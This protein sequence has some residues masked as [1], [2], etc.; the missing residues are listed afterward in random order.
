MADRQVGRGAQRSWLLAVLTVS[1]VYLGWHLDRGWYPHDEGLLGQTAERVLNGE[2]PHRDFDEPYTGLL[3]YAHALAFRVGGIQL[4]VLRIPL[5][6][7]CLLGLAAFFRIVIRIAKP[8]TAASLTLV[9]LVWSV[10]NYPA[11]VP[12]WYNLFLALGGTLA[13]L[14]GIE[15]SKA[16]WLMLAGLAGGL[17][18]LVKLSG[19]F[20]VAGG[21]L[22]LLYLSQEEAGTDAGRS[23]GGMRIIITLALGAFMLALWLAV[24]PYYLPRVILH[25]VIPGATLALGLAIREWATGPGAH[26]WGAL[27]RTTGAFLGGF[28][29]P[30]FV[31]LGWFASQH[32]LGALLRDVFLTSFR[33]VGFATMFPPAPFWLL[34]AVPLVTL[35]RPR[36]ESTGRRWTIPG[37]ASAVILAGLLL[38]ASRT[39]FFYRLVW[40]SVRSAIPLL[41]IVTGGILSWP[42]LSRTWSLPAKRRFALLAMICVMASLVQFPFSAPIYFL[43]VAPLA[44]LAVTALVEAIG[45]T[46]RPLKL[47]A[48]SF[49]AF[50]AILLMNPVAGWNLGFRYYHG[51]P[52]VKLHLPRA[53]IRVSPGD[54]QL[55]QRVVSELREAAGPGAIWA[56]PDAPELYFLG[57]FRNPTRVLFDFLGSPEV[58]D[59]LLWLLESR[60]VKAIAIN[61]GPSFSPPLPASLVQSLRARYPDGEM[62]GRFEVRRR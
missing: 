59:S 43:Y 29:A 5:L 35:L 2:M 39:T 9:A 14:R 41:G 26:Q 13:L 51:S 62:F 3:T 37:W 33:R 4:I 6:L 36:P 32:A 15:E 10:P 8:S 18:F 1:T 20:Y 56:G 52:L 24:R 11:S 42:R 46:P 22:F 19:L 16:R 30:V 49:F 38:V 47:A 40:E 44:L 21:L 54:A 28:A 34:A 58:G 17:S 57:G 23:Q 61:H 48:L 55:Y 50:F 60:D 31:F 27:L 25:F 45:H 12:S 53:G 7:S